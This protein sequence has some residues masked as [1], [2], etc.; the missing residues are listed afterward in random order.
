[1]DG[2]FSD[3]TAEAGVAGGGWSASAGLLDYDNDGKLDLFVTRYLEWDA[4]HSKPCGVTYVST[5]PRGIS[6]G[7]QHSLS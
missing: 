6:P 1:M 2:T 4:K 7:H 5:A 3:V